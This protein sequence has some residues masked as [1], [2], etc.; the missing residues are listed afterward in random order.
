MDKLSSW[1]FRITYP[2]LVLTVFTMCLL[3]Y[4]SYRDYQTKAYQV[5]TI[6]NAMS[7]VN[8]IEGYRSSN[9]ELPQSLDDLVP[10]YFSQLYPARWGDSGWIYK[11]EQKGFSLTVG[12]KTSDSLDFLYPVMMYNS[13][14]DSWIF[15]D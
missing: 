1:F 6:V 2:I 9:R 13:S 4:W 15:D 12:Y 8:A 11:K 5:N 14:N 7:I 3:L 10:M